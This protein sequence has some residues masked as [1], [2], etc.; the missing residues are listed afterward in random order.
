M[1][2]SPTPLSM[3]LK[4][5]AEQLVATANSRVESL[6]V[7]EAIPL[8]A[9]ESTLI[10]DV[11]DIRELKKEGRIPGSLHVPRGFI[12][13]WADPASPYHH[14]AFASGKKLLLHCALGWRSAL[15]A[16]SLQEMGVSNVAHIEGGF[17]GWKEAGGP[18]ESLNGLAENQAG[19]D[20]FDTAPDLRGTG[21][22]KWNHSE[23]ALPMWVADLDF[24]TA[25]EV[26]RAL[27]KR[28]ASG[29]FGYAMPTRELR[30]AVVA[31][32]GEIYDWRIDPDWLVFIPGLVPAI[33]GACR[34]QDGGCG[35]VA[36]NLPNY[37]H[38]VSL[39]SRLDK[40]VAASHL[41]WEQ[42]RWQYDFADIERQARA[43][44]ETAI[45]VNPHNP[46]GRVFPPEETRRLCQLYADTDALILSDEVHSG[47]VLDEEKKHVP[48]AVACPG[49]EDRLITFMGPGKTFNL[50]G[51]NCSYA[52]IA[53]PALRAR[54]CQR[55]LGVLADVTAL[56]YTAT[57][58]ALRDGGPWRLRLLN[59]LR[60]SRDL[61][62]EA[63]APLDPIKMT[64]VEASY[65]AWLDMRSLGLDDP[66]AWL[67]KHGLDLSDGA[68]FGGPGYLRLNFGCPRSRLRQATDILTA[69]VRSLS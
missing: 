68:L 27:K 66:R 64:P 5:T 7:A 60:G 4:Q 41:I 59:Y 52:I 51:I 22:L 6:T 14:Q 54:F 45:I 20:E 21:N 53:D 25:P 39:P 69:A 9:D 10:V 11:R 58:A 17:N 32:T 23:A 65:L 63:I 28:I 18:V 62:A 50:A 43:G 30:E 67:L 47:L 61:L 42:G 31:F 36:I 37:H 13:F 56:A 35:R 46:V 48:T 26:T 34:M 2:T 19:G 38:F 8:A 15:A 12:E 24:P 16:R 3:K 29:H 49:I 33:Y 57:L 44:L 40:E 1:Q 55:N